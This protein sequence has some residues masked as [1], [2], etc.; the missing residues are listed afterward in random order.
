MRGATHAVT[1]RSHTRARGRG[2]PRE[3]APRVDRS[4]SVVAWAVIYARV[5]RR[6]A[7]MEA[8]SHMRQSEPGWESS[9]A[10]ITRQDV[11]NVLLRPFGGT[12]L[13]AWPADGP[14]STSR[15]SAI[16]LAAQHRC[17][18]SK[19]HDGAAR[20]PVSSYGDPKDQA[21]AQW[22]PTSTPR[23]PRG[24][25]RTAFAAFPAGAGSRSS[26]CTAR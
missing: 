18:D 20:P 25:R 24:R 14:E 10:A 22:T 3:A 2:Q 23:C 7:L 1:A 19:R 12:G 21:D 13:A 17:G 9:L 16:D 15:H 5:R 6:R 11:S 8:A 26:A 4:E